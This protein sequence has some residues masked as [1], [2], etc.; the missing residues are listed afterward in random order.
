MNMK[1]ILSVLALALMVTTNA[2]VNAK[3][4]ETVATCNGKTVI[5]ITDCAKAKKSGPTRSGRFA[6]D[7]QDGKINK[8]D[9]RDLS[10]SVGW[11]WDKASS[12]TKIYLFVPYVTGNNFSYDLRE[13]KKVSVTNDWW[14]GDNNY[15]INANGTGKEFKL[16]NNGTVDKNYPN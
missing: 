3:Q 16:L 11:Q 10:K 4:Q 2:A 15:T 9:K 12:K 1:K 7:V 14:T 8:S 6:V 13:H 5:I